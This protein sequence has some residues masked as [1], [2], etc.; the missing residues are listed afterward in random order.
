MPMVFVVDV[1]VVMLHRLVNVV[2]LM[3]LWTPRIEFE[4]NV[5]VDARLQALTAALGTVASQASDFGSHLSIVQNR[6]TF[7]NN[8]INTLRV[9]ADGLAHSER[10][11][12]GTRQDECG[13]RQ[14]HR[15]SSPGVHVRNECP[16]RA[17][18]NCV[19]HRQRRRIACERSRDFGTS[20]FIAG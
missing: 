19:S 20:R 14:F 16:D 15:Q 13:D 8:M 7:T 1:A 17:G 18:N 2:M 5:A 11:R 12:D 3:L 6:Q 4:N 9:G 10:H